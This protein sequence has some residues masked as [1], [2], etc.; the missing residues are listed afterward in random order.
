VVT[1]TAGAVVLVPFPFSDLSEAKLR[2]AVVL[3]NSGRA[4]WILCQITSNPYGDPHAIEMAHESFASGSLRITSYARPGKLFTA[5]QDLMVNQV[6][7]LNSAAF[8]AIIDAVIGILR[9]GLGTP[10]Q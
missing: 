6:A 2:P 5:N 8:R 10:V 3:A 1:P 9:S 7:T 4:D